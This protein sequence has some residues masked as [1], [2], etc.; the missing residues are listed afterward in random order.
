MW[1]KFKIGVKYE[2]DNEGQNDMK[3]LNNLFKNFDAFP[4]LV[5]ICST[6]THIQSRIRTNLA[7][8][9][10]SLGNKIGGWYTNWSVLPTL[11]VQ[12]DDPTIR[13]VFQI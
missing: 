5:L 4:V 9:I 13:K 8:V 7:L 3:M 10:C 11:Y 6:P 1:S 12:R 2:C